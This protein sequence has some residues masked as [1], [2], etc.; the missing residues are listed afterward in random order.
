MPR[1]STYCQSLSGRDQLQLSPH[2][3]LAARL[4][5]LTPVENPGHWTLIRDYSLVNGY[6]PA[7]V[8]DQLSGTLPARGR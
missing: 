4:G 7:D 8:Y 5:Y 6:D 3:G 1:L 2:Q